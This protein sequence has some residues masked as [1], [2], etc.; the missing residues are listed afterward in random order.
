MN[1]DQLSIAAIR[2]TCIDG[3]N[4]AKS[5]H[6]GMA[7]GSAPILY[8]LYTR[9]LV[10]SPSYPNWINRDRFVLSAG[11][12]SMLLYTIL[13][14]AG[15]QVSIDDLKSFRQLDSLTPGHPEFRHTP[16]VDATS[17]PLGQGIAQAVGMAMAERTLAAMY[18]DGGMLF[19]HYTYALCGDGCLEE[20]LSQEAIALAGVQKLNKLIVLY[21]SN[22]ITLDGN[23]DLSSN[24]NTKLRFKASN[25]DVLEVNDGNDVDAIDRA[26][27]KAKKSKDKPTLII[28]HTI[29]GYG[30]KNEN[31]CKVHGSPLGEDD[32]AL[33]KEKYGYSYPAFEIPET[34]YEQFRN[35]FISRGNK[36][37]KKWTKTFKEYKKLHLEDA[38]KIEETLN[39][40]VSKFVFK[41]LPHF[42][43][44]FKD[45]TRNTSQAILNLLNKQVFNLVGGSADV[46]KSVC[47]IIKDETDMTP[48]NPSGRN[49]NFGIREFA[50][51]S[52]QNGM[53]LHGGLRTY[54]G[55][56]LVFSD[57]MKSAIRMAALS[58]LPAI[59]LFSHDSI[60]VGEDGPTHQ[61]IEHLAMLRSMPGINVYRP[62][63]AT[64][65]AASWK[66][67]LLSTDT[68]SAIILS[69]QNLPLMKNSNYEG[70]SK[71]AYVIE[72]EFGTKPDAVIIATGSEVSLA[73]EAKTKLYNL[74]IDV[75]I[76]SMPSQ[77]LF[78]K[79]DKSYQVEV[80]GNDYDHRI[81]VEM[82]TTFGW[83]RFARF[84]MGIDTYGTSA[85]AADA[86]KSFGFTSDALVELVRKVTGR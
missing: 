86:I 83:A 53:L 56:F 63:D 17:G 47:T 9:H 58:K 84:N 6:P 20:G 35:T 36:A 66:L 72:K 62:C 80:L 67:S 16:G 37:I 30:S 13:H 70:V 29:I 2:A 4:K 59:Y 64:E 57:Y 61:P 54:V 52:A 55:C 43:E 33:A 21:D 40:D 48:T 18:K 77:E 19:N 22:A 76:V 34:V 81:S 10:S 38:I 39:N 69:R 74:G 79:Q 14:M 68:P 32:G 85:P 3:I 27:K 12:A 15:Y 46:A 60:A 1:N 49:I 31:T 28:V 5:G 11:H 78:L 8:T 45:S 82:L 73:S 42:E 65:T 41:D 44:G 51:A 50:M 7:L 75:R 71:G 26:I 24:E 25:W 23:L